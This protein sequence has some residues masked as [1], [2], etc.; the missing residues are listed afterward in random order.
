MAFTDCSSD[1]STSSANAW[2]PRVCNAC[3]TE[4][5]PSRSISAIATEAPAAASASAIPRPIPRAPPV[6]NPTLE[7]KSN[8]P[9][10]LGS[11]ALFLPLRG[12]RIRPAASRS[13]EHRDVLDHVMV[14]QN[15]SFFELPCAAV[16]PPNILPAADEQILLPVATAFE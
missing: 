3:A 7:F 16:A 2:R 12:S 10:T 13:E 9:A 5:A 14:E 15:H 11:I 6:T 4:F 8:K 1:T